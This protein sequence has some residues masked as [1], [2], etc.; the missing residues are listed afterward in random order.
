MKLL[1]GEKE[2]LEPAEIAKVQKHLEDTTSAPSGRVLLAE[3]IAVARMTK[4]KD[5]GTRRIQIQCTHTSEEL[6]KLLTRAILHYG[7]ELKE[8][9]APRGPR[10]RRIRNFL[11]H[12]EE[13]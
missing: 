8:G 7:G 12:R 13:G 1:A 9:A 5:S 3:L 10:E 4:V 11:D 2:L 6:G